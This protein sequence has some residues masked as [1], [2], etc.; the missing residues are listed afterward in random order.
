MSLGSKTVKI[1]CLVIF[2]FTF[3][4]SPVSF[5]LDSDLSSLDK[6]KPIVVN[7]D[8]VEYFEEEGRIVAE[9][10]VSITYGDIKLTCDRIE[11]NIKLRQALCEGNVRIE[12]P[13]GVLTGD[14]IRYDFDKKEGEIISAE[15]RALPWYGKAQDTRQ[16]SEKEYVLKNGYITTCDRK[17]PHY[18]MTASEIRVYPD[19]KV[20]AKNVFFYI[21]DVPVLWFPYYY[22]PIM[23]TKSK[24]QFIPGAN[25][26]WGYF[27]L[28]AWRFHINGNT[29]ADVLIDYRHKK[30]FAE[31]IDLYYHSEDIGVPGL[32]WGLFRSY[33]IHQNDR[34]TYEKN[35]T[36]DVRLRKRIQWKHRIDF[37]PGTVAML[38]FNKLSDDAVLKDYFYNEYEENNRVPANFLSIISAKPNYSFGIQV[39]KRFNDFYTVTQK[40]PEVRIDVQDQRLWETPFYYGTETSATVFDKQYA[41]ESSP[42]E[43]VERLDSYHKLSYVTKLGPLNFTPFAEFRETVYSR[44]KWENDVFT[45]ETVGGG[46][47]AFMRFHRVYDVQTDVMD[48]DI[49][50]LRHIVVPSAEYFHTHQPSVDKDNLFQMDELDTLEKENGVTLALENK[51]Q[52]KHGDGDEIR[53]ADLIRFIVSTD[54]LFRMKK[55]KFETEKTGQFRN[56][57]FDLEI[58]PYTWLFID[59]ELEVSPKN[60]A[61]KTGSVELA[62]KP[63]DTFR[64]DLGYRYEKLMPEAR[65]QL[66]F[67]LSYIFSP[68][69][70]VGLY[71]R[72]DIQGKVIEEQQISITRDLHC[73]EMELV[74]NVRGSN[75]VNDDFTV[76]VAF[77]IKAFPDLQ[78]GLSRS[79]SKR[80]S[81][82]S[83]SY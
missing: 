50:G 25:S 79:F 14:R 13:G 66:T 78:L 68:K 23:Q 19:D 1:I 77:R 63:G 10:N 81:G 27:L 37:E 3:T 4:F 16:V 70:R 47:N 73:W 65:N 38:E 40:L 11:V 51:I 6:G 48:L 56:L 42:P 57:T 26:D 18:R 71:E 2:S 32:G 29:K 5:A 44:S 45:R 22:H 52:T 80:A 7:G 72:F 49:N 39:E 31:G 17:K 83:A 34:G 58:S 53:T 54:Y 62:L 55:R 61:V 75:F 76:W 43:Q 24:V 21:G 8:K 28:S 64:L 41:E 67:D 9:G 60:Q 59:S 20:I 74:F 46:V 36:E 35:G 82:P 33:F 12:N 30:G 15:V 69:W